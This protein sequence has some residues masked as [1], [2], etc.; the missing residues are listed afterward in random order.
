MATELNIKDPLAD[1]AFTNDMSV[2]V[3]IS[4]PFEGI[5]NMT[6]PPE[7]VVAVNKEGRLTLKVG[8]G[9][10]EVVPTYA[11]MVAAEA[12]KRAADEEKAAEAKA[13]EAASDTTEGG[14]S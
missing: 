12:A 2:P 5:R 3:T 9:K 6:V 8:K 1:F 4:T 13:K 14:S 11:E 7:G 10:A